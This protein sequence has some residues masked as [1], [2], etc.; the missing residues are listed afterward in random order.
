M[1]VKRQ[2]TVRIRCVKVGFS[3]AIMFIVMDIDWILMDQATIIYMHG[4]GEMWN[5]R[6]QYMALA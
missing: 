2:I 4:A 6:G 3:F 5:M 1:R